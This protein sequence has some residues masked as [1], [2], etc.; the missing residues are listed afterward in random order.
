MN[1]LYGQNIPKIQCLIRKRP[2]TKKE[3]NKNDTDIVEINGQHNVTVRE[4]R[5]SYNT[6]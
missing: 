2:L 5:Y 4:M 1:E 6:K 3:L